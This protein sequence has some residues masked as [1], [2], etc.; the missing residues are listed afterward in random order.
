MHGIDYVRVRC[1]EG[2]ALLSILYGDLDGRE[3][4]K[5]GA[6]VYA[7]GWLTLAVQQNQHSVVKQLSP[8]KQGKERMEI[9][10]RKADTAVTGST[11]EE[12]IR[13]WE[14]GHGVMG[15]GN[16]HSQGNLLLN[17]GLKQYIS[18]HLFPQNSSWSDFCFPKKTFNFYLASM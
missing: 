3:T 17:T 18:T 16:I 4:Q 10:E 8:Y 12:F 13:D 5:G 7:C 15:G 14:Q 9:W 11:S 6:F 1:I 2:G